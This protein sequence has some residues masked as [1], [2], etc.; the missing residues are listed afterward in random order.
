M[1][2][3]IKIANAGVSPEVFLN[4][5]YLTFTDKV[6]RK[7]GELLEGGKSAKYKEM[8]FIISSNGVTGLAGSLH[9]Y[10]NE[11][12]HNYDDFSLTYL[13]SVV[14]DLH[15]RFGIDPFNANLNNVEFG[16]NLEVPFNPDDFIDH[17]VTHNYSQ[18]NLEK[19]KNKNYAQVSYSQFIIK[20]YNKGLQFSLDKNVLRFEVKIVRM[21][22]LDKYGIHTLNDLLV[23]E[24]LL[25]IK[26]LLLKVFDEIIYWDESIKPD[27]LCAFDKEL[28]RDGYNS[29]F[30]QDHLKK[31]GSNASKKFR[32]YQELIRT[33][34]NPE[35]N[36]LRKLI[37]E[38][39]DYLLNKSV[40]DI[41]E[42][43]VVTTK[44]QVRDITGNIENLKI[45]YND[46]KDTSSYNLSIGK[47][48]VPLEPLRRCLVT[49]LDITMQK[50]TSRFLSTT[51]IRY[52]LD[53]YPEIFKMLQDRL[54][55]TWINEPL[56]KRIS[57]IAHSIRNSHHSKRIHTQK[58]IKKLCNSLS[59]FDN[60]EL[61]CQQKKNIANQ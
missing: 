31:S 27:L 20:I 9:K 25:F 2:D 22:K 40:R 14:E 15:E 37:E 19:E 39:W 12:Y 51:G 60:I 46:P 7:T 29:K 41:T 42:F 6:D 49:G 3:F 13:R 33:Y 8:K 26:Q 57:E 61:I 52:Y 58:A 55:D 5:P 59:L 56:D 43:E 45:L 21:A 30:W 16:V 48:L 28:L 35:F 36:S 47:N 10:Y 1:V 4:S 38:K 24:K 34:G 17:L 54:T 53:K 32:R 23:P 11:G 44:Q 18:F 50:G